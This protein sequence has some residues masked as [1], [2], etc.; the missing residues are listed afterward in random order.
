MAQ[1]KVVEFIEKETINTPVGE[2]DVSY[3]EIQEEMLHSELDRNAADFALFSG[4]ES[5]AKKL[6]SQTQQEITHRKA[7][8]WREYRLRKEAGEKLT[9]D[10]IEQAVE[11][12]PIFIDLKHKIIE[13]RFQLDRLSG[14]TKAFERKGYMIQSK[15]ALRR[16]ELEI[17]LQREREENAERYM[18]RKSKQGE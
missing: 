6:V 12:D 5:A 7:E 14:L 2:L 1:D 4:Y 13:Y 10:D 15:A 11:L 17:Q 9:K 8:L 16:K 3:F 18:L